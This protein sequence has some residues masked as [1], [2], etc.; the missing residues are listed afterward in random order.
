MGLKEI[1]RR[2]R[3]G[4]GWWHHQLNAGEEDLWV[5]QGKLSFQGKEGRLI[6]GEVFLGK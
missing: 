2:K 4:W 1:R 3:Y 5:L 6:G